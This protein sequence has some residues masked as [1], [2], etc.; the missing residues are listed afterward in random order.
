MFFSK[1]SYQNSNKRAELCRLV[2]T[3]TKQITVQIDADGIHYESNGSAEEVI[4]Q[5]LRFLSKVVPTYDLARKLI[6]LPDLANLADKISNFAKMTST[7]Q[8]LLT[9]N[10]FPA[11]RA[12]SIVLFMSH[13]ATKISKR[14]VESLNIDEIAN[15]VSKTSKTI[16]NTIVNMQRAGLIERTDRGSYRI[17]QKG[18]MNLESFIDADFANHNR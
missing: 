7:G 17:T 6:Y 11:E 2:E 3:Q 14:P 4:P 15:A 12:I 1:P 16:R 13:L 18:L 8:L 10:D 9:R 5:V